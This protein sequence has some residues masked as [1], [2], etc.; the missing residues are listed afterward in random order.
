MSGLPAP[1]SPAPQPADDMLCPECARP[2]IP[3]TERHADGAE[4]RSWLCDNVYCDQGKREHPCAFAL[5]LKD[6][7]DRL[8][9][10]GFAPGTV[11][12]RPGAHEQPTDTTAGMNLEGL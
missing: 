11:P 10:C 12:R 7:A 5:P 2:L 8:A 6:E 9:A 4:T 3:R 1:W